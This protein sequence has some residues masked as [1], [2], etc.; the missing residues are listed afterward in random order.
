[1]STS[2]TP[3]PHPALIPDSRSIFVFF[4]INM[5][6]TP[7][8]IQD[9]PNVINPEGK[10]TLSLRDLG[11]SD[12]DSLHL[13]NEAFAVVDLTNNMLDEA[14]LLPTWE[15]L[16]TV[17]LANNNISAIGDMKDVALNSL[18]LALNN[19][20]SLKLLVNLRTLDK[21]HTLL[22]LGNPVCKEHHY[23]QFVI[24][25]LP[26]LLVLDCEKVK[27]SERRSAIDLFG[28]SFDTATAAAVALLHGGEEA[29]PVAK[30][31]RMMNTTVS[32]LSKE[33]KEKLVAQL[34]SAQT[35]EEME[36]IQAK[37]RDGTV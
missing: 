22:L 27:Q 9:A 21:I 23:R 24:W 19:L 4:T 33:E 3:S 26:T 16:E 11:V 29:K 31:T 10:L 25:L 2:P 14:G 15:A 34:V 18:L 17:L 5:K 35:M 20:I 12:I 13:A 37:L 30:E 36:L 6:L 7:L 28:E 32:R 1:M 8:V